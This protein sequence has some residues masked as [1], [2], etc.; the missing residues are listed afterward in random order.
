MSRRSTATRLVAAL[1]LTGC[2]VFL[3]LLARDV[4]HW[5]RAMHDADARAAVQPVGPDA[6]NAD[7][8]LPGSLVRGVL[9]IN[10]DLAFRKAVMDTATLIRHHGGSGNQQILVETALAHVVLTD[11]SHARASIAADYLGVLLYGDHTSPQRAIS[12][13]YNSKNPGSTSQTPE[14]KA[15][16]EF[17]TAVRLDP[18]NANAKKN[19]ET[20][21]HT[22][23]PQSQ[24][25][26]PKPGSGDKVGSK[27]SGHQ[28]PGYGY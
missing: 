22:S 19:L 16:A 21:L 4:W 25:S 20:L 14:Q 15:I 13:Y 23:K 27:G 7:T 17:Q 3:L 11:P 10:D 9:G 26:Q 12:P 28:L 24:K 8:V 2:A 6:W 1:L 5:G 18:G